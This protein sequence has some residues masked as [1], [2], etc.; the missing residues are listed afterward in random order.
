MSAFGSDRIEVRRDGPVAIVALD[1]PGRLNVLDLEGW[2][3]LAA[4]TADL[5]ARDDLRCVVVR[6]AGGRA[7]SAGSDIRGFPA[8][9]DT[10]EQVR[11]Y[12]AALQAA[13]EGVEA[14]RHPTVALIEGLC[15]GGGLEIA[16]CCDLRICGESA[17]FGAPI[18]RLGLTMSHAELRPLV[19]LLG[20]G[21]VLEILLEGALL[22]AGRA[23]EIG[24]VNRV[25]PDDRVEQ[26]ALETARRIAA[27]APLVQRWHKRF[28][29]QVARGEPLGEAD[30]DE[31]YASFRTADYREGRSAFLEKRDPRFRGE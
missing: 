20:P 9:R 6:G 21:P 10:P 4:V 22:G 13:L 7:F 17:R 23:R 3:A 16:A 31:A 27:G 19:A 24:L 18:N 14:C 15:V 12:G 2:E 11:R 29:R 30:L 8:Q 1:V 28:I 26:E 25:V 5:S